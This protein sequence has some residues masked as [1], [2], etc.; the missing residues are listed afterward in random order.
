MLWESVFVNASTIRVYFTILSRRLSSAH[1]FFVL[2]FLPG[3]RTPVVCG[4]GA[5]GPEFASQT[6]R[7]RRAELACLR[8]GTFARAK[9]PKA[10]RDCGLGLWRAVR[11]CGYERCISQSVYSSSRI[12]RSFWRCPVR[13]Y[14]AKSVTRCAGRWFL[15]AARNSHA[16]AEREYVSIL[17]TRLPTPRGNATAGRGGRGNLRSKF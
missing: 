3:V 17:R 7:P 2:L 11:R 9:V 13:S 14:P 10:R 1:L 16:F 8:R 6:P 12:R 15:N 4:H 5:M